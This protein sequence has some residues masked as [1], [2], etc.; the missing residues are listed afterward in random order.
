MIKRGNESVD[1]GR[2][3]AISTTRLNGSLPAQS[4]KPPGDVDDEYGGRCVGPVSAESTREEP[5]PADDQVRQSAAGGR[6]RSPRPEDGKIAGAS[7]LDFKLQAV[8]YC[9][10]FVAP[11]YV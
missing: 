7:A 10:I 9:D 4:Q 3:T 1:L 8:V 2:V 5:R 11:L 6:G